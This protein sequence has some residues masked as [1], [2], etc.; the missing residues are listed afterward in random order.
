MNR[1][2]M[3]LYVINEWEKTNERTICNNF[4]AKL[5]HSKSQCEVT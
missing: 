1:Y 2:T 5:L 4:S 3:N